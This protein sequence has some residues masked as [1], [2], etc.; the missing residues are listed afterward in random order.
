MEIRDKSSEVEGFGKDSGACVF[1]EAELK[2]EK[3]NS[4]DDL[5]PCCR[6]KVKQLEGVHQVV[7]KY[8]GEFQNNKAYSADFI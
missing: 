1:N 2:E 6:E 4:L 3:M 5:D 7:L 8:F